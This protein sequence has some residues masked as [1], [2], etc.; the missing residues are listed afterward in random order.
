LPQPARRCQQYSAA[1]AAG[2]GTGDRLFDIVPGQP[3]ASIMPFRVGST[4]GGV[5]MPE[6]GR[7]TVHA[8]GLALL[9]EWIRQLD[10]RCETRQP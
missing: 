2:K 9:N 6:L 8:E 4:E 7:S 1:V 5:M 3:E 10:G